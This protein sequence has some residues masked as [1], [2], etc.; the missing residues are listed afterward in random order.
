MTTLPSVRSFMDPKHHAL[1]A[2]TDIH[3][4]V[5]HLIRKRI[6]GAPVVDADGR[7]LGM[8]TEGECLRL[9]AEGDDQASP[10][11]GTVGEFM[12]RDAIT[13]DPEMNVYHVAGMF[14]R[15]REIRRFPVI[16]GGRVIGVITRKDVLRAVRRGLLPRG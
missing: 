5:R 12:T 10:P 16:E 7:L 15:N 1:A 8:L 14:L 6:T 13:V 11:A 3:D 9:L 2:D 4:A